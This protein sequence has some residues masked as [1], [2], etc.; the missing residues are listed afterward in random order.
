I[1]GLIDKIFFAMGVMLFLQLPHFI[2]QYTQRM[3]G[4]A[5]SQQQQINEYQVIADQHFK[6]DI[7]A[8]I[9]HLQENTDPAVTKSADQIENRINNAQSIANELKVYEQE[10][11]WY[12]VPYFI[13]HMRLDLA[14]GTA[15]NFAPGLPI[16]LWAWGYGL[17]GGV[18]FSLL[19]NGFTKIPQAI[20]RRKQPTSVAK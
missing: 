1:K 13:T 3:G 5:S 11:L 15:Q 9:Q 18:L 17:I 7:R 20:H 12:Q 14:K 4:F 19:F 8:Y 16:N 10:A 2:D 6:G